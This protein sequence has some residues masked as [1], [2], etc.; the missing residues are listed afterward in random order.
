MDEKQN[1][2]ENWNKTILQMIKDVQEKYGHL[3]ETRTIVMSLKS[4]SKEIHAIQVKI[5][6]G[7]DGP[8]HNPPP[9]RL[10]W[11]DQK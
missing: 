4:A 11:E 5:A 9:E 7:I 2:A 3:P 8:E 10:P 1:N 6:E